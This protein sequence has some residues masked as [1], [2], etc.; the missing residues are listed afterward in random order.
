MENYT[1]FPPPKKAPPC[2]GVVVLD[3][4]SADN[5]QPSLIIRTRRL[6]KTS[7]RSFGLRCLQ[8]DLPQNREA[9]K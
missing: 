2:E 3:F 7:L 8:C 9:H 4:E 6:L 5:S 1:Q